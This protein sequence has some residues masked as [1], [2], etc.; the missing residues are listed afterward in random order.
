MNIAVG[1]ALEISKIVSP[2][3]S[4]MH[5]GSGM[6]NVFATPAMIALMESCSMELLLKQLPEG[7]NSV[8]IEVNV[9]HLKATPIGMRVRCRAEIL[10]VDGR[11]VLLKV[12]AYD[13]RGKIGEGTH[14]RFIVNVDHFM[15]K[16]GV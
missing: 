12:D 16:I 10:Q 7:F 13:E 6:V 11:A 15:S 9:K 14:R 5:Y 2:E 1:E 3:D 8:G 4:A